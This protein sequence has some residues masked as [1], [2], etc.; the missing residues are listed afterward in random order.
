[1]EHLLLYSLYLYVKYDCAFCLYFKQSISAHTL[2]LTCWQYASVHNRLLL[3][4]TGLLQL[5]VQP[6]HV[7]RRRHSPHLPSCSIFPSGY[8]TRVYGISCE[9]KEEEEEVMMQRGGDGSPTAA[10]LQGKHFVGAG[11]EE[12]SMTCVTAHFSVNQSVDH[13]KIN[14]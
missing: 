13:S 6:V 10:W 14:K 1:M 3:C 11:G 7:R 8:C 5:A 4:R 12:R 9:E 2:L